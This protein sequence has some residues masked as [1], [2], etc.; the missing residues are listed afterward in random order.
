MN[1]NAIGAISEALGSVAVIV[2][3]GYLAIQVRKQTLE[4]RLTATRE[5]AVQFQDALRS[6]TED[7]RFAAIWLR[8]VQDYDG[9]PSVDRIRLTL[10]FQRVCRIM[11]QQYLHTRR[12][13]V[14]PAFFESIDL[15]FRE[16]LTFPGVQRWWELSREHF[17]A[18]FRR[19]VDALMTAA[20]ERGYSS[21][22]KSGMPVRGDAPV[23]AVDGL[24]GA[25]QA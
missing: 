21:S 10:S 1:W 14:D 17:G 9:L 24:D 5:L 19:R 7:G 15:A 8:G 16:F 22:F 20:R 18:E 13:N 6:V 4:A 3:V 11:E 12:G 25:P 2:S 23:P